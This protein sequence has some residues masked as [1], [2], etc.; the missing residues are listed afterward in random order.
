MIKSNLKNRGLIFCYCLSSIPFI[1]STS[2]IAHPPASCLDLNVRRAALSLYLGN[3]ARNQSDQENE[4]GTKWYL[5]L[6][7]FKKQ[8]WTRRLQHQAETLPCLLV[9]SSSDTLSY[10]V[11]RE[12]NAKCGAGFCH[13]VSVTGFEVAASSDRLLPR[14]STT[15]CPAAS[16][17]HG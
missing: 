5:V 1:W 17:I 4:K 9:Q 11:R 10:F 16:S 15:G 14:R 3:V 6:T 12:W 7:C 8:R 2:A 13:L